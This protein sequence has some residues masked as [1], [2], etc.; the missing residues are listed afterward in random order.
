MENLQFGNRKGSVRILCLGAHS[1]DIEIG[2][3]GLL[4]QML[5][6]R[7]AVEI[8]WVVFS[9]VGAREQEARKSAALF[10]RG[11]RRHRLLISRFRDG[12]FPQ[13]FGAIKEVFEELKKSG[14][15]DLVLTH[16][17]NDRHQDHRVLSDLVWNTFRDHFVLEYEVPK[18]DGDLGS[19][20]AF[21]ALDRR[22]CETKIRY[23]QRV[24]GTQRSKHWFDAE[25]FRG[26]MRLR[27]MEC[28]APHGYAEGFYCRKAA[29]RFE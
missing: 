10:L 25:T 5:R 13:Q 21:V 15:P 26:L 27:G 1:D 8:D 2:C 11:A 29:I 24:F 19:P 9:A 20:N 12:F 17:R 22:S 4:L 3:G 14:S 23:L 16:Y 28:R 18:Y 7:R 6:T